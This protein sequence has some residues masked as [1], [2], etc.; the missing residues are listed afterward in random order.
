[1]KPT[2][3]PQSYCGS[4]SSGLTSSVS[5]WLT[6]M[7][8]QNNYIEKVDMFDTLCIGFLVWKYLNCFV[9][10][11]LA[12]SWQYHQY[13]FGLQHQSKQRLN[14]LPLELWGRGY[15][16]VLPGLSN[17]EPLVQRWGWCLAQNSAGRRLNRKQTN[18]KCRKWRNSKLLKTYFWFS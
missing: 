18:W 6:S 17:W 12:L 7:L 13:I 3:L 15:I 14:N 2:D 1:M 8:H 16:G 10:T 9:L 4:T 11:C 5:S